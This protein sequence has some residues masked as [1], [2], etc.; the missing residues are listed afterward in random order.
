MS[1]KADVLARLGRV[2]RARA[3]VYESA[4]TS[5][6]TLNWRAPTTYP[7]QVLGDLVMLR[8]RSRGAVRNDGYAKGVIDKL[9][10]NIIGTGMKPLC[11]AE[12]K[13]FR[14]EADSLWTRW[15]DESDA[16]GLLDF[17]GQQAQATRC[18]LEAG[19][20][21]VRLRPRLESDGLCVPLQVQVLE[22]EQCPLDYTLTAPNG[23][24]VKAGIEFNKIGRRVAYYFWQSRP[25]DPNE[26]DFSKLLRVP[27]TS[28]LHVFKP[29]RAG[30]LRGLPH[31]T[32]AMIRLRELDKYS[33]ATLLRQQLSAMFVAFLKNMTTEAPADVLTGE[34]LTET[35]GDHPVLSL[36]PGAFQ[37]LNPGEEVQFSDPPDVP[38]GYEEYVKGHLRAVSAAT[39]VPYEVLTGDMSQVNDRTV[40]V[41]L[42]EFRRQI[43]ADQHQ[44]IAFQLCRPVWA[45]WMDSAVESGALSVVPAPAPV[46]ELGTI[47][48][49]PGTDPL[50]PPVPP[51][52][53]K[54][55]P[56]PFPPK[57]AAFPPAPAKPADPA[58]NVP[59]PDP[60][61]EPDAALADAEQKA[62]GGDYYLDPSPWL[63]VLWMPQGWPYIHPVQDVQAAKEAI[64]NGLTSRSAVVAQQGEDAA[65]VDAQQ[66]EDNARADELDLTYDSDGR[67]SGTGAAAGGGFGA[68]PPLG[69]QPAM[70]VMP[71]EEPAPVDPEAPLPVPPPPPQPAAP[72]ARR[73]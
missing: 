30:Q 26:L 11:Q 73:S 58:E 9:V 13:A 62:S 57:A 35:E 70:P 23:N 3:A 69:G 48:P 61:A 56:A 21:F 60:A 25:G 22:P 41:I 68:P 14:K 54:K 38:S 46:P 5:R 44:T 24:R 66:A 53:E 15:T 19:E 6:R 55:A 10:T 20:V 32:Q 4:G 71:G 37:A 67:S 34:T 16:D 50:A 36:Q 59:A 8:D 28:I 1:T 63:K 52:A 17:Y 65:Q 64:R 27:A 72:A 29:L 49:E 12:D 18:W 39:G 33:D 43:Q 2:P 40:R 7:N 45:A 47:V 51:P 31:L 42:H